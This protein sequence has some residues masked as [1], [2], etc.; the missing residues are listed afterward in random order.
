MSQPELESELVSMNVFAAILAGGS[1]TRMGNP[2]KPKQFLMLGGK[3]ILAHTVE[4][5]CLTGLFDAVIVLCPK[6]WMQ[7]TKDL[8]RKYCPQFASDIVVTAGG[9]S[10]NDTVKNAI[11]YVEHNYKTDGETV[12]V[13][14][15]AVRPFVTYRIITE[16][17]EAAKKYDACDTVIPATDTIVESTNGETITTIPPRNNYYQGQTPQSF[18]LQKLKNLIDGL[19]EQEAESLTDACKIFVLRQEPVALV[20]GETSNMKITYPQDMRLAR[21][22]LGE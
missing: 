18:N 20:M 3:P 10:R 1:G 11:A 13:T 22:L 12:L 17:I 6:T 7:Q 4:K 16:H 2:D 9:E 19:S 15:D 21:A 8:I 14:H 5:F